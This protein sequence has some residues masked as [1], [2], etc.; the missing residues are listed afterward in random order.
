MTNTEIDAVIEAMRH[1]AEH[2]IEDF[3]R[4]YTALVTLRTQRDDLAETVEEQR[5]QADAWDE[6][7]MYG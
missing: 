4:I 6:P 1:D 5:R 2:D 7:E 3:K